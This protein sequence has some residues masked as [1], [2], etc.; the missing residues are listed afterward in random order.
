MT[1]VRPHR[2]QLIFDV[3]ISNLRDKSGALQTTL[4]RDGIVG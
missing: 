2:R 3:V 4:A 1:S